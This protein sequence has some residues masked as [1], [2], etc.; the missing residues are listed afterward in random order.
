MWDRGLLAKMAV[1][2]GSLGGGAI[3]LMH[4]PLCLTFMLE[5][6]HSWGLHQIVIGKLPCGFWGF[7]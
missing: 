2:G 7:P 4:S 5:S 3:L 6:A 1:F